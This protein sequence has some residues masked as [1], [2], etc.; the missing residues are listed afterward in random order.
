MDLFNTKKAPA[1]L[2]PTEDEAGKEV[3]AEV[4]QDD[5]RS[6]RRAILDLS[7]FERHLRSRPT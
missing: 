4:P 7:R 3:Y 1:G 5:Y 2:F 6:I